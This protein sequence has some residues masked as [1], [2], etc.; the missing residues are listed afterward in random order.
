LVGVDLAAPD[1]PFSL[2]QRALAAA[3]SFARVDGEK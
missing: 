3:E 1:P 2:A